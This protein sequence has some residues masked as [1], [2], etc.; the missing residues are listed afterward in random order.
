MAMKRLLQLESSFLYYPLLF[1]KVL[2]DVSK[3]SLRQ[4]LVH[5]PKDNDTRI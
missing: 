4:S 5:L 2:A 3:K 1:Q